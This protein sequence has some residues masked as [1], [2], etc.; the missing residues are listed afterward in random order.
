[1]ASEQQ[2]I[3]PGKKH[4]VPKVSC[5]RG[6]LS[7]GIKRVKGTSSTSNDHTNGLPLND[8]ILLR[9]FAVFLSMSDL[10]RCAATCSQWRHLVSRNAAYICR[11]MPRLDSFVRNLAMGF[12]YQKQEK[13]DGSCEAPFNVMLFMRFRQVSM[14]WFLSE[15]RFRSAHLV[16][17]RKGRLILEL[18]RASLAAVLSLVVCNPM[19]REVL[20]LPPL[21][22]KDRVGGYACVLLNA[23]DSP[24]SSSGFCVLIVYNRRG[25][26]VCRSYS[27]DTKNWGPED[28]TTGAK[29]SSKCLHKM[30]AATMV[31]NV[32]FWQVERLLFGLCLD[33]LKAKLK[34]LS[35]PWYTDKY[36][37][38]CKENHLLAAWPDGML[39][40]VSVMVD[41]L[42][43]V[44]TC[45]I[46]VMFLNVGG[47][48]LW[49]GWGSEENMISIDIQP[50]LPYGTTLVHLHGVCEQSGLIFF[51]A[52]SNWFGN[53]TW[54]MYMLDLQRKV[55]QLL[56]VDNHCRGP[57]NCKRFFPYEMDR[58][59]YLMSLGGR[60][61]TQ[62]DH[63]HV[64]LV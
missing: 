29:V 48:K 60:D 24:C 37:F 27:S 6:W 21:S 10:V 44:S 42:V 17:C 52:C 41:S 49:N 59:T 40:V 4:D 39:G 9:I 34:D 2:V 7:H 11:S 62:A 25:S 26:L 19:T 16:A 58:A 36:F 3:D 18:R 57:E 53:I 31:Q 5:R 15:E 8:D 47:D 23:D 13:E 38:H 30:K 61:F 50:F 22:G 43:Y 46:F 1:M 33:T 56:D 28:S 63:R 45:M 32:V 35:F 20:F 12:F 64:N 51:A 54:R 14:G 55:V